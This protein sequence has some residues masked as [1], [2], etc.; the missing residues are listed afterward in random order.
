MKQQYYYIDS[1]LLEKYKELYDSIDVDMIQTTREFCILN[2]YKALSA[3][4]AYYKGD[5]KA[6]SALSKE[7]KSYLHILPDIEIQ[8]DRE[9]AKMTAEEI[10]NDNLN[11]L[12]KYRRLRKE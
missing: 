1:S 12:K 3:I 7:W 9:E 8:V 5:Y 10:T 11:I 4:D 6:L 2:N